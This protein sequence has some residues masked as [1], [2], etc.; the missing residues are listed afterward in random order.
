MIKEIKTNSSKKS[1]IIVINNN[2]INFNQEL[3]N[4]E[5]NEPR[6]YI[7]YSKED[8]EHFDY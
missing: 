4:I 7:V 2:K 6:E 1:K 8:S 5:K 3:W